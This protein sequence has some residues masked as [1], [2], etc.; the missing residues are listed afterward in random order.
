MNKQMKWK[1]TTD[2]FVLEGGMTQ[3]EENY[4]SDPS[5]GRIDPTL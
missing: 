4:S 2:K 1:I 3:M 5:V